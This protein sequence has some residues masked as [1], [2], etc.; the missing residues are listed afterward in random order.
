MEHI[1]TIHRGDLSLGKCV[2]T[3]IH[4]RTNYWGMARLSSKKDEPGSID[5]HT[6]T[7][8]FSDKLKRIEPWEAE[9]ILGVRL[10][11]DGNMNT[12]YCFRK[13]QAD[14]FGIKLCNAPFTPY[15]AWTVYQCRYR[16]ML[17]YPL[18][19][20]T[21]TRKQLDSIQ[22]KFIYLLLPKLGM[23]RHTPRAV[24]YGP[25]K[26]G[27]RNL[28]DMRI[29]QP[30]QHLRRTL[31]HMR[32]LDNTGKLMIITKRDTQL[33]S[34]LST[35]FYKNDPDIY[36]YVTKNTRWHYL[37]QEIYK[38]NINIE[39][40]NE[41]LPRAKYENDRNIMEVA[42]AD[43]KYNNQK[44]KWKL[45]I[46]NNCRMY[47]GVIFLSELVG[48]TGRINNN[49]LTGEFRE[50]PTVEYNYPMDR[51]PTKAAWNEWKYFIFRNF[52]VGAYK[53]NPPLYMPIPQLPYDTDHTTNRTNESS[54]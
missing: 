34:G 46:I 43:P 50:R 53:V 47:L 48:P 25:M 15:D 13:D 49:Y 6:E 16:T 33:E 44:S 8:G 41:W 23:N 36:N 39:F 2:L 9:R 17:G 5:V 18:P 7:Q 54:T 20:T 21:F 40:Y 24:V 10:P 38:Y 28:I 32:R 35:P 45:E 51:K 3:I 19:V 26:Y 14:S 11:A 12:E 1:I 42:A 22:K 31:G 37:W 30:T 27:G 4:W 29:E 52:L